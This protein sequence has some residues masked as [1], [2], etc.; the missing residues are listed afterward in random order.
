[1]IATIAW[2][3]LRFH[4]R[5]SLPKNRTFN[6]EYHHDDGLSALLPLRPQVDGRKFIIPAINER[7]HMSHTYPTPYA[8]NGL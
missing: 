7:L 8:D 2:N 5:D 4:M 1:M 3:P 6:A